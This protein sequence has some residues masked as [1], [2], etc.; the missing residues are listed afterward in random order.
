MTFDDTVAD[1]GFEREVDSVDP[2]NI[3]EGN[4]T[5]VVPFEALKSIASGQVSI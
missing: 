1:R 3:M 2:P 4:V 5:K